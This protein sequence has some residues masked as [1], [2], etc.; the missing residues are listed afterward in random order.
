MS[1]GFNRVILKGGVS[2]DI[3]V[4]YL[5]SGS[6]VTE[7]GLAVNR[8]W[9]DK[10]TNA[11]KDDCTFVD[12]TLWGKQAEIA[13]EYL[14]KGS[15]VLIEGR[16]QLESWDD[17]ETGQKRQKLKVVGETLLMLNSRQGGG[18]STGGQRGSET[19]DSPV[20]SQT[21]PF[22]SGGDIPF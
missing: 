13:G 7:I 11:K 12:V 15:Q 19:G 18:T 20:I 5:P 8:S 1:L 22:Q 3:Q 6:A 16:L 10:A 14:A 2:R 4:R 21:D 9:F 17:K